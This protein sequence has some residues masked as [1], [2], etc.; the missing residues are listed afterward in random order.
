MKLR[1][2]LAITA[3]LTVFLPATAQAAPTL[4]IGL[5]Y[6]IGGIGD[7]S[8]ND[9]AAAGL[10]KAKKQFDFTVSAVVTDGSTADRDRRIRGLIA[11]NCDLIIAIGSGYAGTLQELA[12]E[13]PTMQFAILNDA[14][15]AALNVT[16]LI[17]AETQG[18]YLA[19]FSA[20]QISKTGKVA[21]ITT[22]NQADI[23]A[24]GFRAG[25]LAS[26]KKVVPIVKY[27]DGSSTAA[28]KQ[29]VAAR[30]DIVY[31]ATSGSISEAFKVIVDANTAKNRKKSA[32]IIKVISTEP[33][34]YLTVTSSTKKY[35]VASVIKRVDKVMYD[36]ISVT[37]EGEQ[38][39]DF[40]EDGA[41]IYGRRYGIKGG[42]IEFAIR[43]GELALYR[44]AINAAAATAEK[45]P[46]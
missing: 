33:D 25:V 6:D 22:K 27:L 26:K 4:S 12:F 17:F 43:T 14:S 18:A 24:N 45:I 35:L 13:F 23:Y 21:M 32:P 7:R 20:A 8:M 2:A 42:G 29:V 36:L 46:A 5:A 31:M 1:I 37:L 40:I 34:Q 28:I 30:A 9:A 38:F 15:V 11:K 41:D 10:E 39:L 16:S 19:G 44:S 3:L